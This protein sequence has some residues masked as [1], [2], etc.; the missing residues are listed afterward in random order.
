[1]RRRFGTILGLSFGDLFSGFESCLLLGSNFVT[2]SS[3][4]FELEIKPAVSFTGSSRILPLE[5]SCTPMRASLGSSTSTFVVLH[6]V[7]MV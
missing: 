5:M 3:C 2:T 7:T 4:R 6:V 1:M